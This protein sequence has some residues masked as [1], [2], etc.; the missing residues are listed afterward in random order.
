MD[1]DSFDKWMY[2]NAYMQSTRERRV[3]LLKGLNVDL[4]E[5]EDLDIAKWLSELGRSDIAKNN[6]VK[7]INLYLKFKGREFKLKSKPI[8]GDSDIWIPTSEEVGCLLS[9]ELDDVFK[10]SRARLLL[11]IIFEAGLRSGE[12]RTIR[13]SDVR[14]RTI[15]SVLFYYINTIGKGKKQRQ[16]PISIKLHEEIMN[17]KRHYS[18]KSDYIFSL[19]YRDKPLSE[20]WVTKLCK[21]V[22]RRVGVP[23]FH[24]HAARHYRA[25]ELLEQKVNLEAVRKFLGHAKLNT[26]QIYLRASDS[27]H[28]TE[29]GTLDHYFQEASKSERC[30]TEQTQKDREWTLRDTRTEL[31]DG[32]GFDSN[33]DLVVQFQSAQAAC[34]SRGDSYVITFSFNLPVFENHVDPDYLNRSGWDALNAPK[35]PAGLSSVG[36][37]RLTN[38]FRK[39]TPT[40]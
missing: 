40:D 23:K 15:K 31:T 4:D 9:V 20:N 26:T 10:T 1:L 11:R 5:L 34:I 27:I 6:I 21:D 38:A 3:S 7:A 33:G 12:V 25:I 14:Q 35:G 8:G 22:G 24:A 32:G 2:A 30:K 16:V 17:Y 36:P 39:G 13:Y 29:L 28:F 18:S 19:S 37:T